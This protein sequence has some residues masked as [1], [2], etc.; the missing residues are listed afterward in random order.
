MATVEAKTSPSRMWSYIHFR[1]LKDKFLLMDPECN[2]VIGNDDMP[3]VHDGKSCHFKK[4]S[5]VDA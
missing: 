1:N 2:L 3:V 5:S 4:N